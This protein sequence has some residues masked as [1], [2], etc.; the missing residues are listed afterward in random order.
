M[1]TASTLYRALTAS[2]SHQTFG[3]CSYFESL[4]CISVRIQSALSEISCWGQF[5]S[6]RLNHAHVTGFSDAQH[7]VLLSHVRP[8]CSS[9]GG[10]DGILFYSKGFFL[11]LTAVTKNWSTSL[12]SI[13]GKAAL[14]T[15]RLIANV[16]IWKTYWYSI[17][18]SAW[19]DSC[20]KVKVEWRRNWQQWTKIRHGQHCHIDVPCS[21]LQSHVA[22][23]LIFILLI[24][25]YGLAYLPYILKM[26]SS[27]HR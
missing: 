18:H 17:N 22:F 15:C 20:R 6:A 5:L 25:R 16:V 12:R 7:L 23:Q 8:Q 2:W 24:G 13:D 10:S 9:Y 11:I 3:F 26:Y 1:T 27:K 14:D 19:T 21:M 4:T